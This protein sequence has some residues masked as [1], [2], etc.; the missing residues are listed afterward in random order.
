MR[1]MVRTLIRSFQFLTLATVAMGTLL[2]APGDA[3]PRLMEADPA[4]EK[5]T[6]IRPSSIPGAGNGLFALVRIKE[7]QTIGTYGGRLIR[8]DEYPKGNAYIATIKE[9]AYKAAGVYRYI[10]GKDTPSHV[11][12]INFAPSKI[13]GKSTQLQNS[14]IKQLCEAPY[15]IFVAN[16][17]IEPG[18]EIMSSYGPSYHYDRFMNIKAVQDFFCN[19]A[20]I[21]CSAGFKYDH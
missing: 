16:R 4:L 6:E 13:N 10:D 12:R 15:F 11:T 1:Q 7:G 2:G 14:R 5:Q 9:C 17:D 18:E 19:K 21:D 8:A 20:K 3:D